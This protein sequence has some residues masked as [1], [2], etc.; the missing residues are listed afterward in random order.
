MDFCQKVETSENLKKKVGTS[1]FFLKKLKFREKSWILRTFPIPPP[2]FTNS[3][4]KKK[5]LDFDWSYLK[6]VERVSFEGKDDLTEFISNKV[7]F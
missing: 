5:K 7:V 4:K 2:A 1:D 3:Q 6:E